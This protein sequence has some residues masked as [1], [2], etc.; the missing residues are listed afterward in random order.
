MAGRVTART[1][2]QGCWPG[3]R[4]RVSSRGEPGLEDVVDEGAQIIAQD[5]QDREHDNREQ[6][7]DQGILDKGLTAPIGRSS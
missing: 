6:D 5:Q 4:G 2:G 3:R 7:D 1:R